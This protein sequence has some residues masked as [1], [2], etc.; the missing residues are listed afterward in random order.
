MSAQTLTEYLVCYRTAHH[1]MREVF[2]TPDWAMERAKNL[3]T[4][5]RV[6]KHTTTYTKEVIYAE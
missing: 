3:D 1:E 4:P 6:E 5:A 2:K